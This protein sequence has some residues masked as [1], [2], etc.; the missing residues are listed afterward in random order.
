MQ[1]NV[2]ECITHIGQ[3]PCLS[4]KDIQRFGFLITVSSVPAIS[5]HLTVPQAALESFISHFETVSQTLSFML[6]YTATKKGILPKLMLGGAGVTKFTEALA[7]TLG[8]AN[9]KVGTEM[10]RIGKLYGFTNEKEFGEFLQNEVL[11]DPTYDYQLDASVLPHILS[12]K[13]VVMDSKIW[14]LLLGRPQAFDQRTPSFVH[15]FSPLNTFRP[16]QINIGATNEAHIATK[17]MW[18]RQLQ[19]ATEAGIPYEKSLHDVE[20]EQ[21][22]RWFTDF[23]R[24]WKTY[25]ILYTRASFIRNSH[26][27]IKTDP[28]VSELA[29]I[30]LAQLRLDYG[31]AFVEFLQQVS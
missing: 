29:D 31:S 14:A 6:R 23:I 15:P 24:F 25:R 22:D 8:Y 27:L 11:R 12:G 10:R 4:K 20:Q 1:K 16:A 17:R 7:H 19:I 9:I 2:A 28:S 21:M 30:A 13:R 3:P 18:N 5:E 26:Y